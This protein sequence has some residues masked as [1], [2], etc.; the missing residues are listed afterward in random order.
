MDS[1]KGIVCKTLDY[2]DSSKILYIYTAEG[3]KSIIARGV[4]KLNS[5]NRFLSQ[6]GNLIEF[7]TTNGKLPTLKEGDLIN[8]F[9][10]ISNDLESYTYVAH[11]LELLHGTIDEYSDH[12]KM[13]DFVTRLLLL[14]NEGID[15]ETLTFIFELKLLYFLGY[16][17]NFRGCQVC[18]ESKDLV[19]SV[20]D[21]GL[22]CRK[23]IKDYSEAFDS[24]VYSVLKALYYMDINQY[25]TLDISKNLRIMIRHII[26]IS[27]DEFVSYKTKSRG[28]LKQIIK[29]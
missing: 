27:F 13:F 25:I 24:D 15:A 4:K 19:Y 17:L 20:S 7:S 2:K 6:V 8:D 28:I 16:G 3:N 21:G 5:K 12:A 11:I 14:F 26:D 10:T 18:S 9:P 1:V 22:I 23:H 29:Y